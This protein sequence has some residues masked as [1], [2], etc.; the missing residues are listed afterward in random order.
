MLG[1]FLGEWGIKNTEFESVQKVVV[2]FY[3]VSAGTGEIL[4]NPDVL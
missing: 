3:V 1:I 2:G 4:P